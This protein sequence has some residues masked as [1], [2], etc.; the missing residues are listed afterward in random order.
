MIFTFSACKVQKNFT[1]KERALSFS[2]GNGLSFEN[3]IIVKY[4]KSVEELI[5]AQKRFIQKEN[6]QDVNWIIKEKNYL[7]DLKMEV[8]QLANQPLDSTYN[9][10]FDLQFF[11]PKN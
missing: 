3:A 6:E 1:P 7:I 9:L 10:Y 11:K 2:G 5:E 4:A 8:F